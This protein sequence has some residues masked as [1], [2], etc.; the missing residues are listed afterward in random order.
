LKNA[1]LLARYV[2]RHAVDQHA[3]HAV[4]RDALR[5][6]DS[7]Y[8]LRAA[9]GHGGYLNTRAVTVMNVV[10]RLNQHPVSLLRLS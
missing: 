8:G 1:D 5:V 4:R 10:R 6:K 2:D 9:G 3:G 7:G